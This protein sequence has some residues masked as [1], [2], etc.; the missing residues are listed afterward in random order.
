MN[1]HIAFLL[2][3]ASIL[4]LSSCA[5]Y[6]NRGRVDTKKDI[7][8]EKK[9]IEFQYSFFEGNKQKMLGNF[10]DAGAYYLRCIELKPKDGASNYE[11]ASLLAMGE[12]YSNAIKY[13]ETAYESDQ[14]NK[15]YQA[16]L[17]SLYKSSGNLKKSS[18]LLEDMI[19]KHPD[20]Y[21]SYLELTDTY[22]K[23]NQPKEA[24]KTLNKFEKQYGY[25]DALMVEK[26]RIFI[27][28]GKYS[29]ARLEVQKMIK[30]EPEN[31]YYYI[32]L[33]D[34]YMEEGK[35]EKAFEIYQNILKIDPE[36]GRVH[37][38][39]SEYYQ[40]KGDEQKAFAEL[41]KAIE[42]DDVDLDL[43]IK[44]LFSYVRIKNPTNEEQKQVYKLVN[45]L[46]DKYPNEM[47]VH[48][49]YSDILVKDKNYKDAKTQLL[50]ITKH[51]PNN[52]AV[53]EQLLYID[54][55]LGDF[56]SLYKN[57]TK[58]IEYF[59]NKSIAYFFSG[60]SAY[61]IQKYQKATEYLELGLDFAASD[62]V[63]S[64]Q[65]YT[66]LGDSYHKLKKNKESDKA[67]EEAI[68]LNPSNYYV[69]NNYAYY[70]SIRE[71]K[72]NRAKEL[73][74]EVI[75]AYPNNG[76]YLDTYA[77]VLYKNKDFKEALEIIEQA[78]LNGGDKS[79]VI[80][81]HYGDILFVN[82]KKGEAVEKW[83]EAQ[84]VG[85]G[86]NLLKQK[87]EEQKLVE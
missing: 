29:E 28:Q 75:K 85:E 87:I 5:S 26:N 18:I 2:V 82:N 55:Q 32:L 66:I 52:Y 22:L 48:S 61:Q 21:N 70:L 60:L 14:N 71:E 7:K 57:S 30:L 77:W 37:F 9:E 86:S 8:S 64:A 43:K 78:Y 3:F 63:L 50:I 39:L 44:L 76:T 62:T 59:P 72:L 46:L 68:K 38:A 84:K 25:S 51:T 24:I 40:Q 69:H 54:N 42:S 36:N 23:M 15:W 56:E 67:Y 47:K 31:S 80:I 17:V 58:M 12:D 74:K 49:I 34:L 6:K 35:R 16:L 20:D 79:A 1:K 4:L 45:I 81:E 10:S 65:F 83:E 53:W 33:A 73:M 27:A 13:A 19:E 11:F 41:E